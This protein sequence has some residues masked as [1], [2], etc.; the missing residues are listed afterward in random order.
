MLEDPGSDEGDLRFAGDTDDGE[1]E[2]GEPNEFGKTVRWQ[3]GSEGEASKMEANDRRRSDCLPATS[4][5][6]SSALPNKGDV[7]ES[8]FP[9]PEAPETTR[10]SCSGVV[11]MLEPSS[12]G[13]LSVFRILESSIS[14]GF[15]SAKA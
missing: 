5:M 6:L 7:C 12:S 3:E 15:D 10:I 8:P 4:S 13:A 2:D 1:E 9:D 11:K 14:R